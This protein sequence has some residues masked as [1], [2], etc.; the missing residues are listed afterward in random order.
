MSEEEKTKECIKWIGAECIEWKMKNNRL[1]ATINTKTCPRKTLDEVKKT[2]SEMEGLS[3]NF[4]D[5]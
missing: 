2:M 3:I 4:K 5:E 1:T